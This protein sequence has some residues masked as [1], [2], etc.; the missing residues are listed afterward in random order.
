MVSM[1][2]SGKMRMG[3]KEVEITKFKP[4]ERKY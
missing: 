4:E 3:W 2:D 1:D